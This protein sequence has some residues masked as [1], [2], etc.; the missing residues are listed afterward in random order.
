MSKIL[1]RIKSKYYL[2][3]KIVLT[4]SSVGLLFYLSDPDQVVRY[5]SQIDLTQLLFIIILKFFTDLFKIRKWMLLARVQLPTFTFWNAVRSFYKG[6]TLAVIT[7]FSVGELGRGVMATKSNKVE[8]SGLVILDKAFDLATVAMFSMMGFAI[9]SRQTILAFG[10]LIC[11]YICILLLK[12]LPVL[13]ENIGFLSKIKIGFFQNL[14]SGI[15]SVSITTTL[16]AGLLSTIYFLLFYWQ[17]YLILS[18]YGDQFPY[19][20]V[21][22][23]PLITLSTI[24]PITVGGLGIREGTAIIL[25][26]RYNIPEAVAFN[27]F[28][29][30]FVIAN[31]LAGI[32]GAMFFLLPESDYEK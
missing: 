2:L 24:L 28:F 31:V 18:A 5:L 21:F 9:L 13:F 14:I 6:M 27:T 19:E 4:I 7:P 30:H 20:V 26:G 16:R 11:Y 22:Y 8:L 23:F 3:L 15:K 32:L 17:A 12:E 25:L 10:L 1:K 29:L